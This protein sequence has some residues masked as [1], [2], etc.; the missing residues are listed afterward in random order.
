[1]TVVSDFIAQSVADKTLE[2]S[3]TVDLT[4]SLSAAERKRSQT[5]ASKSSEIE[6]KQKLRRVRHR[7]DCWNRSA[8][9]NAADSTTPQ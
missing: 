9:R 7:V 1:M 2:R 6:Y 8:S 3:N 5:S 4:E